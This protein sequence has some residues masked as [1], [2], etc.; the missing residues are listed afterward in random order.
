DWAWSITPAITNGQL[1]GYVFVGIKDTEED[2][3]GAAFSS[4]H[5]VKVDTAGVVL[6]DKS[7]TQ[8]G[9]Y[10]IDGRDVRQTSDG[11]FLIGGYNMSPSVNG[12][13][14]Y[15]LKTDSLGNK[16]WDTSISQNG[17]AYTVKSV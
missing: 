5:F 7:F 8:A 17:S 14:Y 11:G 4:L 1:T 10:R 15:L 3:P 9:G 6:W 2:P 13:A 12:T 16:I